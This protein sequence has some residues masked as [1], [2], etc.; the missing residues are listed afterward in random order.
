MN[1]V[2][3]NGEQQDLNFSNN[4]LDHMVPL[5]ISITR[6]SRNQVNV[7]KSQ[8][9]ANEHDQER[10]TEIEDNLHSE[11][12]IWGDKMSKLG[13]TPVGIW[14]VLVPGVETNF[15]WEYPSSSLT[16]I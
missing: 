3:I 7:L 6:K 16:E 1:V 13:M 10:V 15:E 2:S 12:R 9:K 11:V 8:I 14:K 4:D 5:L